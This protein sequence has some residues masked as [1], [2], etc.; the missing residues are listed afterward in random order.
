MSLAQSLLVIGLYVYGPP[1]Q[2][3]NAQPKRNEQHQPVEHWSSIYSET[4]PQIQ[5][6][7]ERTAKLTMLGGVS[8]FTE[9][10]HFN[11]GLQTYYRNASASG[12][13]LISFLSFTSSSFLP[14]SRPFV[15]LVSMIRFQPSRA[16][17]E[18][19]VTTKDPQKI[20][21]EIG[22]EK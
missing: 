20:D 3:D 14:S 9:V 22:D 2:R 11:F 7:I 6:D 10:S 17:N 19:P 12:F 21:E 5:C 4:R 8:H 16:N 18:D 13:Q 15:A 1:G